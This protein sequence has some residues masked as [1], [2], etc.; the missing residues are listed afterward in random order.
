MPDVPKEI[1]AVTYLRVSTQD[2]NPHNQRS[3][4]KRYA[5][6]RQWTLV[7]EYLDHG[8]SGALRDRPGLQ[9][10]MQDARRR[11]FDVV[12]VW[13]FDRFARSTRHLLEALHEF[14]GLGVGF[15]SFSEGID[16]GTP[17]GEAMFTMVAAIS[18]LER[19]ILRERI[20]AGIRRAK[21]EGKKLG[22][23]PAEVPREE[24]LRL[25]RQGLSVRQ[26]ALTLGISKTAVGRV[27]KDLSPPEPPAQ[28][29][30]PHPN[31]LPVAV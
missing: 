23:P 31:V 18:Q 17:L 4:L 6:A 30:L 3:D 15:V 14:K 1:R 24:I 7:A 19:D 27:T 9:K 28:Q 10:L 29:H 5:E 26:V 22:R 21:A 16:L 20:Q 2:Q 11:R 12:L 25:R 8:F 13:R